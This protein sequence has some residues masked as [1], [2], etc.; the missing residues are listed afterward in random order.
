MADSNPLVSICIPAFNS[1]AFIHRALMSCINQ[2][3]QNIEIV[4]GDNASTD[5]TLEIIKEYAGKDSRIKFF[6][7][8][9]N[10]GSG[11]NYLECAKHASGHF[12]QALGSDDWLSRNYVEE[13]VRSFLSN[14]EA[15]SV[16]SNMVTLEILPPLPPRFLSEG[17]IKSDKYPMEW[18]FRK[19]YSHPYLGSMGYQSFMRR[20]DF[21]KAMEKAMSNPVN[22]LDRGERREPID[23]TIFWEVLINYEYIVVTNKS[24]VILSAHGKDH[25][26]LQG[27][28]FESKEGFI[29]YAL[30]VRRAYEAFYSKS[31]KLKTYVKKLRFSFG[32][33]VIGSVV[34]FVLKEKKFRF[35]DWKKKIVALNNIFFEDYSLGGKC[36]VLLS[37]PHYFLFKLLKRRL[38]RLISK[39]HPFV[40]TSNHFLTEE[41]MFKI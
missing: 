6:Q 7:N 31:E 14:P 25:V 35:L 18:F 16:F 20:G 22:F 32:L 21:I 30:A 19:A 38:V 3:Y 2:T 17:I 12:M 40:P 11:N 5:N 15:A 26:G 36:L 39:Q 9:S 24:A 13:G 10:I 8:K 41:L 23:S 28:F 33:G 29:Y 37:A 4:V 34:S 27:D 1:G